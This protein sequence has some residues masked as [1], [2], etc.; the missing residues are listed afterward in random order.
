MQ[1]QAMPSDVAR[2]SCQ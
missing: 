1:S 2:K